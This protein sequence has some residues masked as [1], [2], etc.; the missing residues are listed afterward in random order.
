MKLFSDDYLMHYGIK[1]MKWKKRKAPDGGYTDT[2]TID[3]SASETA[4][5]MD[6]EKQYSTNRHNLKTRDDFE[7]MARVRRIAQNERRIQKAR[8]EAYLEGKTKEVNYRRVLAKFEARRRN[9]RLAEQ[10]NAMR[11][12]RT[13][14]GAY[15]TDESRRGSDDRNYTNTR[16]WRKES[17]HLKRR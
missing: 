12:A 13:S 14:S 3:E 8:K 6:L 4:R 9:D 11:R 17:G 15:A 16:M 5:R 2:D 7:R 10:G 1:G